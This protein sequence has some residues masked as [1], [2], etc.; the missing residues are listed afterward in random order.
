MPDAFDIINSGEYDN[1]QKNQDAFDIINNQDRSALGEIYTGLKRGVVG[2][3]PE[4]VGKAIQWGS[5]E[6]KSPDVYNF[7]KTLAENAQA[8]LNRPENKLSPESHNVVTNALAEGGEMIAPSLAIPAVVGAGMAALPEAAIG[9]TAA[10]GISAIAGAIPM[11]MSQAQSTY[12]NVKKAGASDEDARAAGWKSGAIEAGGETVGTYLG[13]KLLGV[14]GRVLGKA[15]QEGMGGVISNATNKE[16]WKPY[17]KQLFQTALGETATEMGQSY[18]QSKVEQSYGVQNDPGQQALDVI[19]P[20]LG[21][22]ALLA[23]FGLAGHFKNTKR[24]EAIDSLLSD[25]QAAPPEARTKIVEMLHR[26]AVANKVPDADQWLSGAMED[27][28]SG[29]PIRRSAEQSSQTQPPPIRETL[30]YLTN[31]KK[32]NPKEFDRLMI[33]H[34]GM[35]K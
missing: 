18:G 24:A 30:S 20:T 29:A 8:R 22:T 7:G 9:G 12:E 14:G 15:A 26:E 23:P 6:K 4:M 2:G 34:R 5:D 3:V 28:A 11:G 16:L 21:M 25:P 10:L 1:P 31:L 19:A 27:I 13:G 35:A 32:T 33:E 17:G